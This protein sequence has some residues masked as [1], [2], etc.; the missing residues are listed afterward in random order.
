VANITM[1][2]LLTYQHKKRL[3]A[4][5]PAPAKPRKTKRK[6]IIVAKKPPTKVRVFL[7]DC[8]WEHGMVTAFTVSEARAKVKQRLGF[9]SGERLPKECV[10]R[11][12]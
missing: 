1:T 2:N 10:F 9:K 12:V 3:R 8:V 5:Q 11:E 4:S 6:V 7:F